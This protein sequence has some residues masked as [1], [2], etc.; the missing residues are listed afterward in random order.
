MNTRR[1]RHSV[2]PRMKR[3]G[4]IV[5]CRQ[6]SDFFDLGN[7]AGASHI[8]LNKIYRVARDEI[9]KGVAHVEVLA[10][11]DRRPTFFAEYRVTRDIFDEKRLFEPEGAAVCKRIASFE[12]DVNTVA[13]VRVG[14]DD[15]VF[16]ELLTHGSHDANILIEIETDLDLYAM[17]SLVGKSAR[18]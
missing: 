15:E 7:P 2:T 4:Y 10:N 3:D 8:R 6:S 9:F 12:S 18:T 11:C 17:K 13:L 1:Q 5:L 14:H 16:A